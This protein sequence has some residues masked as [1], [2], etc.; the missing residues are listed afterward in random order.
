M[1][2]ARYDRASRGRRSPIGLRRSASNGARAR[3][4]EPRQHRGIAGES[5]RRQRRRIE[6]SGGDGVVA[7]DRPGGRIV[8]AAPRTRCP[9]W[10][11]PVRDGSPSPGRRR[12]SRPPPRLPRAPRAPRRRARSRPTRRTRR[13]GTTTPRRSVP[14]RAARAGPARRRPRPPP[15][16]RRPCWRRRR[17]RT[18]DR[19]GGACHPGDGARASRR[20]AGTIASRRRGRARGRSAPGDRRRVGCEHGVVGHDRQVLLDRPRDEEPQEAR[21]RDPRNPTPG[22]R[23]RRRRRRGR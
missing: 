23:R 8:A 17:S 7:R 15:R 10:A 22:A 16:R 2:R 5:Q 14:A 18:Q 21:W 6:P 3:R 20:S 12:R 13:A 4:R 1:T 19:L 9:R 11:D